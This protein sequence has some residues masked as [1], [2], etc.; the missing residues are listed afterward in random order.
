MRIIAVTWN[1]QV[2]GV[3]GCSHNSYAERKLWN[4]ELGTRASQPGTSSLVDRRL[5][6][7]GY[8]YR[9]ALPVYPASRI[10]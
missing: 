1:K 6:S 4:L 2:L 5:L 10:L 8:A 3:L 9:S 7:S